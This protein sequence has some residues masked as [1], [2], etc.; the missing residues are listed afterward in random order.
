[1]TTN[2]TFNYEAAKAELKEQYGNA[3]FDE[4]EI[5]GA[6]GLLIGNNECYDGNDFYHYFLT[7]TAL[8]KCYYDTIDEEGNEIELD[9]IDYDAPAQ[10]I[11]IGR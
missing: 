10:M 6:K 5:D 7:E 1:M 3:C 2:N 9:C 4:Y 8:Y 11:K